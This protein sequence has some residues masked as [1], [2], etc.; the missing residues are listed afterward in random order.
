MRK[1]VKIKRIEIVSLV[2]FFNKTKLSIRMLQKI[3]GKRNVL[4]KKCVCLIKNKY[5]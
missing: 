5:F 3:Q 2:G 1:S 4:L